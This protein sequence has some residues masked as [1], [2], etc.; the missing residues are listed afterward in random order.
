LR[1]TN[2]RYLPSSCAKTVSGWNA[3]VSSII[4]LVG[5]Q[6]EV[7]EDSGGRRFTK[8]GVHTFLICI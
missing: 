2:T 5:V 7:V 3:S 4:R 6:V 1:S 8:M